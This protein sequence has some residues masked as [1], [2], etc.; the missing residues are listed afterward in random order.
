MVNLANTVLD[1]LDKVATARDY[2]SILNP[3][4]CNLRLSTFIFK[5]KD[6]IFFVFFRTLNKI[7][8]LT[9]LAY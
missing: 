8:G 3:R 4:T 9:R 7:K 5:I 6:T 1:C 2:V